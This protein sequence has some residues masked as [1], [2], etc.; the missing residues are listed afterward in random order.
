MAKVDSIQTLR[1]ESFALDYIE[2]HPTRGL[3]WF[4]TGWCPMFLAKERWVGQSRSIPT[5][6]AE[7]DRTTPSG[8]GDQLIKTYGESDS[9]S[10]ME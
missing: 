3:S 4:A 10:R 8:R 5:S 1:A 6:R 7:V 2:G 9:K